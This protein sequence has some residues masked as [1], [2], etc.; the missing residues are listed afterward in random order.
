MGGY[1]NGTESTGAGK[2]VA[3]T[4]FRWNKPARLAQLPAFESLMN[5]VH[6]TKISFGVFPGRFSFHKAFSQ[7]M[8]RKYDMLVKMV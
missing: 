2:S 7:K 1:S 4:S 8:L 5:I 3:G 6:I